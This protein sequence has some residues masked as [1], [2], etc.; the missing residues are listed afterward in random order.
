MVL[1][2]DPFALPD[3]DIWTT[4]VRMTFVDG[5]AVYEKA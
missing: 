2:R 5:E 3:K 4:R 1:D